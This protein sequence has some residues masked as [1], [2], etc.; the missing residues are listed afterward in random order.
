MWAEEILRTP[1]SRMS[2]FNIELLKKL[3]NYC[4]GVFFVCFLF[5]VV[6]FAT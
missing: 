4:F 2:D 5:V 6:V 3:I 1:V